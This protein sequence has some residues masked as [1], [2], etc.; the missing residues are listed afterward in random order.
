MRNLLTVGFVLQYVKPIDVEGCTRGVEG[1]RHA[2]TGQL[3][4]FDLTQPRYRE[5]PIPRDENEVVESGRWMQLP[6]EGEFQG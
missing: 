5:T 6:G 1:W 3:R 4:E 2:E